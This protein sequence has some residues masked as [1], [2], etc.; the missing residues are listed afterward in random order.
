M[1]PPNGGIPASAIIDI[2]DARKVQGIFL[3][4]PVT[5]VKF[6]V[7][8]CFSI[9]PTAINKVPLKIPCRIAI[10]RAASIASSVPI[11]TPTIM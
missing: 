11:P 10:K 2:R 3:I 1:N 7:P 4:K 9:A 8:V 5:S 6:V